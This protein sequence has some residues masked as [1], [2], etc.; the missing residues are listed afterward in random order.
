MCERPVS[1]G[2]WAIFGGRL[3][4][5]LATIPPL[6]GIWGAMR[7]YWITYAE[8]FK[9]DP[10]YIGYA[11]VHMAPVIAIAI[12]AYFLTGIIL[13]FVSCKRR[14]VHAPVFAGTGTLLFWSAVLCMAEMI[15]LL[16]Y[17]HMPMG[18]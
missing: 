7:H 13:L 10:P 8:M 15:I 4:L 1:R 18:S 14:W 5:L 16:C 3:F 6:L 11:Y 12:L 17:H 9:M 2:E